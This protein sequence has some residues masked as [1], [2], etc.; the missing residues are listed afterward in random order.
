MM[1]Q[2]PSSPVQS[3]EP[4]WVHPLNFPALPIS[5]RMQGTH[6]GTY[7]A[8][9]GG[10]LSLPS[11]CWR[12]GLRCTRWWSPRPP[13]CACCWSP[14]SSCPCWTGRC[15]GHSCGWS[16]PCW[17]WLM[18]QWLPNCK[19]PSLPTAL[20]AETKEIQRRQMLMIQPVDYWSTAQ[21]WD[22]GVVEEWTVQQDEDFGHPGKY[23]K[24]ASL[25]IDS[26]RVL[27]CKK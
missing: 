6:I 21:Q 17:C 18:S 20:S 14:R 9:T 1:A 8:S 11:R 4:G 22:D 5:G 15:S 16:R 13:W 25:W 19:R 3:L 12:T 23:L 27:N 10:A 7:S 2:A 24:V 26:A